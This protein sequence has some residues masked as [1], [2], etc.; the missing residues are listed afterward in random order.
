MNTLTFG[1]RNIRTPACEFRHFYD[2]CFS[3]L[4]AFNLWLWL[5]FRPLFTR[6]NYLVFKVLATCLWKR[7][8]SSGCK[9][10]CIQYN[11]IS[12]IH[13]RIESG[14]GF[15]TPLAVFSAAFF[16]SSLSRY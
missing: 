2:F 10:V 12:L 15:S 9:P 4:A 13:G 1:M 3:Y 16:L 8:K 5:V 14:L 6:H 11:W 7:I